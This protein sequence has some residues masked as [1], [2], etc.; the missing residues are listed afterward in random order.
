M[1]DRR[2]ELKPK[3]LDAKSA[4]EMAGVISSIKGWHK[5]FEDI[6]SAAERL[7]LDAEHFELAPPKL[8]H[9][10][11]VAADIEAYVGSCDLFEEYLA[12]LGAITKEDWISFRSRT[13]VFDDFVVEWV[14]RSAKCPPGAISD[15]L[16]REL[17]LFRDV[18]PVLR[19]CRGD[20]FL[21]EHWAIFYKR[22]LLLLWLLLSC[23]LLL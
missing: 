18:A 20:A 9:M 22:L 17:A 5:E 12:E 7:R 23:S 4:D 8:A 2:F 15:H 16:R 1:V 14:D 10:D 21:S 6:A 13:Y 11:D 3:K 19:H